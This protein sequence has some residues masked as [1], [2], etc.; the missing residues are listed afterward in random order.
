MDAPE[1]VRR[2]RARSRGWSAQQ[3]A[4]RE[5]AQVPLD[6]KRERADVILDNS[7]DPEQLRQEIQKFQRQ[8]KGINPQDDP[9]GL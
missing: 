7:G 9:N 8:A 5:A 6:E 1:P 2:A 4:G 3:F